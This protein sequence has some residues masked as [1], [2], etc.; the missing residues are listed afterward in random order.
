MS[1]WKI[2]PASFD[3]GLGY[4]M[5]AEIEPQHFDHLRKIGEKFT[6]TILEKEEEIILTSLS[7]AALKKLH[8]RIEQEVINRGEIPLRYDQ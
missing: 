8:Y 1:G 5:R 3:N 7:T 2:T 4:Q 6:Q